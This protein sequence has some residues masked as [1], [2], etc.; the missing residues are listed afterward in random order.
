[1]KV[2]RV[3]GMPGSLDNAPFPVPEFLAQPLVARLA[4]AG[5]VVRPVWYLW[6][7]DIFWVITGEW[8]RLEQRLTANPLFE[9]V[10]DTC[11][12]T[13]GTVRQVIAGG[14]G[15]IVP[16]DE[17]R[18]RRKLARYLGPDEAGWDARFRM[19]SE[20]TTRI[21]WARLIPDRL[22]IA[23]QSFQPTIAAAPLTSSGL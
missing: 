19:R 7:Q 11:D 13:T 16:F 23:E 4:T 18:G 6:E 17:A 22:V 3:D 5:P 9:L 10:V 21:R 1:M 2:V 8:S 14:T 15:S 20:Q 12:V